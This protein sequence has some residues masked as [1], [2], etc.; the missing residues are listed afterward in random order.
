MFRSKLPA[1]PTSLVLGIIAIVLGIAGC[2]CYGISAIIPLGL[3]IAGLVMANKSLRVY[4]ENPE[5]YDRSSYTNVNTARVINIIAVVLNSLT[6]LVFIVVFA[7]YGTFISTAV[8]EGIRQDQLNDDYEYY[9][10][11]E[12]ETDSLKVDEDVY[13]IE[14]EIDSI[15]IDSI[16]NKN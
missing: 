9:E 7:I 8:L 11:Y 10:D 14:K 5:V 13:E 6:F 12:W 2:C 16:L 3:S 4:R 1:D 15:N